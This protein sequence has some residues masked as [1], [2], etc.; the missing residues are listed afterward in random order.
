MCFVCGLENPAGL[1]LH[2]YDDGKETV[3][4]DFVIA[5][6]HQGFPGVVHGGI[7]AAILDEVGC[8]SMMIG[9]PDRFGMTAKME[10]RYRQPVP[11]G[12]PL[13]A[14][15]RL[16]KD[17]GRL[18]THGP[19]PRHPLDA[20]PPFNARHGKWNAIEITRGCV[21]ACSF[22]QT[23][24]AFKA[25]FRHRSVADVAAHVRTMRKGGARYVRFLS[26]TALS[27]GS[28]DESVQLDAVEELLAA[29]R[30]ALGEGGR[31]YFG[32]FPSELR[33]EHVTPEAL[34][35]LRR[36]VD[37]DVLVIGPTNIASRMPV[38]RNADVGFHG[39]FLPD[40]A[41]RNLFL[42]GVSTAIRPVFAQYS[43]RSSCRL[44]ST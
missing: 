35:V 8:R 44:L 42:P 23:P 6:A 25:R 41:S 2:F 40:P 12:V 28:E 19:G 20:F 13:K 4:S 33:P 36:W 37:N 3:W 17:R 22:C 11:Q 18:V 21:Y 9:A 30:E 38:Q 14:I 32:T 43:I 31:I 27:Y 1:C 15:G 10:L 39:S 5:P 7:C 34:A 26:P 29:T 16:V 24:F